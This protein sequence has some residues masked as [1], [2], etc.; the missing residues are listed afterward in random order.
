M[1][2]HNGGSWE[3][4]NPL[5]NVMVRMFFN[6]S[7][8]IWLTDL[9]QWLHYLSLKLL[10]SKRLKPPAVSRK[11][12][13]P[14]AATPLTTA[15]TESDC[16]N[17]LVDIEAWLGNCIGAI[18][19]PKAVMKRKGRRKTQALVPTKAQITTGPS[20]AGEVVAYAVKRGWVKPMA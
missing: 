14:E 20:C 18:A 13:T 12:R 17:C 6:P 4:F 1:R 11:A 7:V 2:E 3:D 8:V 19:K 16:Y 9:A 5:T 15:F 10:H